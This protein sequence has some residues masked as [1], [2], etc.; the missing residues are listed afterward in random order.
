MT[1][2]AKSTRKASAHESGRTPRQ[3]AGQDDKA[4]KERVS[5]EVRREVDRAI[6]KNE[7]ALRR[8]AD[9]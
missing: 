9:H 6:D 7:D 2:A 5:D 3:P 8:L 4:L 1:T